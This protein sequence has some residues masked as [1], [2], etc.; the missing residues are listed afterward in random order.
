MINQLAGQRVLVTGATGFIGGYVARQLQAA[1]AHVVALARSSDR[2]SSLAQSGI[3]CVY[4]DITDRARMETLLTQSP[5]GIVMHIAAWLGLPPD[6]R[7]AEAV[8]VAATRSLAEISAQAGAARFVFTSS[9][10]VYGPLGSRDVDE[11]TP[12][13][14]HGDHYG[15]SK[16]RAE[17]ALWAVSAQTG[18]PCVVVRPGMVYGPGSPGWTVRMLKIA[19]RGVMPLA[20]GGHGTAHPI[21]IDDLVDL[22]LLAASHPAA[23]GE[24]FNAVDNGPLT[25]AQFLGGYMAMIPTRRAIRLPGWM[26]RAA[27]FVADPFVARYKLRSIAA[28]LCGRGVISNQRARQVLG[29]QPRV[30]LPEGLRRSEEWLRAEGYL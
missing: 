30:P 22:L 20:D 28:Q 29:W 5:P 16:V 15:D 2:G 27:A 8:N 7:L 6:R 19:R 3:E 25:F 17:Q 11:S 24:T 14:P 10:A 4:G 18:L 9:I 13:R 21:F 26:F 1:G 12:V 23:E